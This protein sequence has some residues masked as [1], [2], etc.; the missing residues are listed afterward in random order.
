MPPTIIFSV[1]LPWVTDFFGD[2]ADG[3]ALQPTLYSLAGSPKTAGRDAKRNNYQMKPWDRIYRMIHCDLYWRHCF[4]FTGYFIHDFFD[5]LLHDLRS[6]GLS[7]S[8]IPSCTGKVSYGK[9]MDNKNVAACFVTC[10]AAKR[11]E[12]QCWAFYHPRIKPVLQQIRLF[13][14]CVN[15]NF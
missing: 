13:A 4:C 3:G 15:N 12:W 1:Y 14:S 9:L 10:I 5:V 2:F 8:P 7:W 11:V 6:P